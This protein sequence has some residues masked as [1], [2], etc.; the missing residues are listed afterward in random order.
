MDEVFVGVEG[1]DGVWLAIEITDDA[2]IAVDLRQAD[3]QILGE[4]SLEGAQ[5]AA[6]DLVDALDE[7]ERRDGF[8]A[9]VGVKHNVAGEQG[10][11]ALHV[12]A[13][14]GFEEAFE[15]ISLFALRGF[16]ARAHGADM[17]LGTAENLAAIGFTLAEDGSDLGVLVIKDLAEQKDGAL[18]WREAL[19]HD[20]KGHGQRF[21]DADHLQRIASETGDDGFGQPLADILLALNPRRLQVVDAQPADD[22]DEESSRRA[23][24]FVAGLL[25]THESLLQHVF[26]I[27]HAPQHSVCNR[28]EQTPVLIEYCQLDRNFWIVRQHFANRLA[29]FSIL[30]YFPSMLTRCAQIRPYGSKRTKIASY[31]RPESHSFRD[32]PDT[33]ADGVDDRLLPALPFVF[34]VPRKELYF[35]A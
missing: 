35:R 20:K 1:K 25:P 31:P 27:S 14:C 6:G 15:Q 8:A 18:D 19:Q 30:Q 34:A 3:I 33:D 26:R 17:L 28:K 2:G 11:Q 12:T 29:I 32:N 4:Q 7:V 21:I 13:A 5:C 10:D 24:L 16:E 22:R 23:N 9:A